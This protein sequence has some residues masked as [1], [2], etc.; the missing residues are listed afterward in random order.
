MTV[1]GGRAV[2]D[3][4]T[5]ARV[6]MNALWVLLIGAVLYLVLVLAHRLEI[7]VIPCGI[8]LL[9]TALLRPYVNRLERAGLGRG[10][11]TLVVVLVFW[12]VLG[13]VGYLITVRATGE[14]PR[15]VDEATG[16]VQDL[17]RTLTRGPF[18]LADVQINTL[19]DKAVSY[20]QGHRSAITT[21]ALSGVRVLLDV[22]TATV[23]ALFVGLYLMY[24]GSRVFTWLLRYAVP[25]RRSEQVDRFGHAAYHALSGYLRGQLIVSLF[26][27]VVITVLLLILNVPLA[28]PLGVVVALGSLVPLVGAIVAGGLAVLVTLV[29]HGPVLALVVVVVLLIENQAEAHLLQ[30]FVVGRSVELHPLA[31]ALGLTTGTVV[32]GIWGA[33][34]V[35]PL[36]AALNAG[37]KAVR[38]DGDT[39]PAAPA[40]RPR[41]SGRRR[42][43][44]R[45][46]GR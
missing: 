6:G 26:H 44:A 5:L 39:P 18:H 3:T 7:V 34:F 21:Q 37:W 41:R 46:A 28:L 1:P 33:L 2:R 8:A 20:L 43:T 40:E 12:A 30:P 27:G 19:S 9:F 31:V 32:A 36:M 38:D 25:S 16:T 17:R 45:V 24:D 13:T 42:P 22:A 35:V 14:I 15:L 11:A 23:L 10:L 29:T 4:G